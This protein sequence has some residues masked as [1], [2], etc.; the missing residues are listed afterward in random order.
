ML[1]AN[2]HHTPL[3]YET[4]P[5]WK[6]FTP[7][8]QFWTFIIQVI[9]LHSSLQILNFRHFNAFFMTTDEQ[10]TARNLTTVPLWQLK[11]DVIQTSLDI[12]QAFNRQ[13]NKIMQAEIHSKPPLHCNWQHFL[14]SRIFYN[15]SI[16]DY[17]TYEVRK[18]KHSSSH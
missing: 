4:F 9:G 8:S 17:C 15:P 13:L 10:P 16:V 2:F 5:N 11:S 3:D 7:I 1:P 12:I 6:E 14:F 18:N